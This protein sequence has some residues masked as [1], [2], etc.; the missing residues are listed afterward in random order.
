M[1]VD[2]LSHHKKLTI[3]KSS[4]GILDFDFN[5][6]EFTSLLRFSVYSVKDN[7]CDFD[8][9]NP[10]HCL[11]LKEARILESY[12][13]AHVSLVAF[14]WLKPGQYVSTHID[15][16]DFFEEHHRVHLPICTH[17]SI[18]MIINDVEFHMESGHYYEIDN[19]LPH[20]ISNNSD[21]D[22]IHLI[23]DLKP[24]SS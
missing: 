13:D 16:G 6:I 4:S 22:R 11:A 21:V 7:V 10:V 2:S 3:P 23:I 18:K 12:F 24:K 1:H 19:T 15:P 9:N 20:S 17:Q 14:H 5:S 8:L